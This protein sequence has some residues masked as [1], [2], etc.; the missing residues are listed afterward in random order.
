MS[1]SV[2]AMLWELWQTSRMELLSRLGYS[3][4]LVLALVESMRR[5]GKADLLETARGI[6][7]LVAVIS[8]WISMGWIRELDRENSGFSYRLGFTR[9][10]STL[11]LV[12]VPLAFA[13]MISV[14]C[15]LVPTML[16]VQ[17][18]GTPQPIV[19]PAVFTACSCVWLT[20][21]TWSPTSFP[22]KMAAMILTFAVMV[23]LLVIHHANREYE[24][25]FMLAIGRPDYFQLGWTHYVLLLAMTAAAI[26]GA[27]VAVGWQRRG[28]KLSISEPTSALVAG[29]FAGDAV[30]K[31]FRNR[32]TA[33]FSYEFRRCGPPVLLLGIAGPILL[34]L[35]GRVMI[36][37][38]PHVAKQNTIWQGEPVLW[39][40]GLLLSPVIYQ[41][42]GAHGTVGLRRVEGVWRFSAFDATRSMS[43]GQLIAVKLIAV[44]VCSIVAWSFMWMGALLYIM[45]GGNDLMEPGI[46]AAALQ[47]VGDVPAYWWFLAF[48]S[49]TISY[50]SL[51][52]VML[53]F[54]LWMPLHPRLFV[55][56]SVFA[57]SHIGL[58][59]FD[60]ERKWLGAGWWTAYA[61]VVAIVL[62][63]ACVYAIRKAIRVRA[64]SRQTLGWLIAL[65]LVHVATTIA[66]T[67]K[68]P[69][70][71]SVPAAVAV[72]LGASLLVPLG[73][74]ALAPLALAS[75]RHQA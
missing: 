68:S 12:L 6:V 58:A 16:F 60:K 17:L 73:A 75:L 30:R 41:I 36:L 19:A 54:G 26:F 71:N 53:A 34:W 23:V 15:F 35:F 39:L 56:L 55:G 31:P 40:I 47:I 63:L 43:N 20:A 10:V 50:I 61:Y 44:A 3:V 1:S 28:E 14:V 67:L 72:L 74:T 51:T 2:R 5:T 62:T 4:L 9:P 37:M 29:M 65:W 32:M 48:C 24:A 59:I 45:S 22:D 70:S 8:S 46:S 49:V 13:T 38:Y 69:E 42:L 57:Y 66:L 18:T 11:Q 33:Q 27:V 7:V 21:A 25:P 64:I 52:S